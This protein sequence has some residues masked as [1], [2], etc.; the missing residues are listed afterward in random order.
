MTVK[1][2]SERE[3]LRRAIDRFVKVVTKVREEGE[4]VQQEKAIGQ[5]EGGERGRPQ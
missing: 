2:P 4:Q 3:A 5:G 1:I